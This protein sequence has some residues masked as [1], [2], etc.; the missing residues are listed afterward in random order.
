MNIKTNQDAQKFFPY[1]WVLLTPPVVIL[2][3]SWYCVTYLEYVF[4][5]ITFY[6]TDSDDEILMDKFSRVE[7][8]LL[9][10]ENTFSTA[11]FAVAAVSVIFTIVAYFNI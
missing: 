1:K 5:Y 4:R 3:M 11:F 9:H 2:F 6:L 7:E 10:Y 8:T